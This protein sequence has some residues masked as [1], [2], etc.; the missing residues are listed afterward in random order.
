MIIEKL[1]K[2]NAKGLSHLFLDI[3]DEMASVFPKKAISAFK[4]ENSESEI[5]RL[6]QRD[7]WLYLIARDGDSI[8][9]V[10]HG[11]IYGGVF[12]LMWIGVR[13]DLRGGGMGRALLQGLE[14]EVA[15]SCH[16]IQLISATGLGAL[17]FYEKNGY[18][19]ECILK[20]AWWGVDYHYLG[21]TL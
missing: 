3:F 1:K 2:E 18:K 5:K 17:G 21:K 16:K 14:K 10:A 20:N 8:V 11:Y 13:K 15:K 19:E 7:N 6:M 4:S 9:G 12:Y